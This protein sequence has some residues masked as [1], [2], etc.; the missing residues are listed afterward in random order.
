MNES[1]WYPGKKINNSFNKLNNKFHLDLAADN[2]NVII[3]L[4]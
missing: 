3:S 2:F 1:M 4:I